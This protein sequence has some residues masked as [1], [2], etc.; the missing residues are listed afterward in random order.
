MNELSVAKMPLGEV[1]REQTT[2]AE[3]VV[4]LE[5]PKELSKDSVE[6]FEYWV[7]GIIRKARR[8]AGLPVSGKK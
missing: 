5:W 6:E 4:L 3:G 1:D 7:N 8:K 2:L